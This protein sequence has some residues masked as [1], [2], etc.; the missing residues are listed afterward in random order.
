MYKSKRSKATDIPKSV[1]DKVWERDNHRC[2]LCGS[3]IAGPWCHFISRNK[4]GLGVEQNIFTACQECHRKFDSGTKEQRAVL[5]KRVK[6][7]LEHCYN[8][9]NWEEMVYKK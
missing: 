8:G 5:N 9:I 4:G 1:K 3:P 2:I 7:Y 6:H